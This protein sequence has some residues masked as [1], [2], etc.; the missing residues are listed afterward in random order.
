MTAPQEPCSNY[1][2]PSTLLLSWVLFAKAVPSKS[3]RTLESKGPGDQQITLVDLVMEAKRWYKH[4]RIT[5]VIYEEASYSNA[6]LAR[7]CFTFREP[8]WGNERFLWMP[9]SGFYRLL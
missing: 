6:T 1:S 4:S 2:G 8:L 5:A 9:L 3:A 7:E